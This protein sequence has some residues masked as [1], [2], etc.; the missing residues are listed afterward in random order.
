MVARNTIANYFGQGYT[1]LVAIVVMPMYLGILGPEE[2]GLIG[3][4]TLFS[5]WSQLFTTGLNPTPSRQVAVFD[6]RNGLTSAEFRAILRSIA[7]AVLALSLIIAAAVWLAGGL[8]AA[9]CLNA[10]H[11]PTDTIASAVAAMRIVAANSQL[12]LR[13]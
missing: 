1:I 4:L 6:G 12:G 8:I 3:F 2:F 13:P 11:T 7:L 5:S 10:T 9:G